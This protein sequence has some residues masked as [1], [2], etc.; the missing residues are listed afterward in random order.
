MLFPVIPL[1]LISLAIAAEFGTSLYNYLNEY[2]NDVSF[3][4]HL[5]GAIAGL[6]IGI[7]VLRNL[8]VQS[9]EKKL[10]WICITLYM[11][12]I[13]SFVLVHIFKI[14]LILFNKILLCQTYS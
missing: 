4:A 6:L 5:F 7:G 13:L 8:R 1:A 3:L 10:W 2:T 9:W 11:I 14:D 12:M